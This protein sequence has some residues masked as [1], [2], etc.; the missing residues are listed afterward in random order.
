M[1]RLA[2]VMPAYNEEACIEAVARKWLSVLDI[3]PGELIVV[4]DGSR[5]KTGALLD[6]VAK[7]DRRLRVVHQK[8]AGHGAA[9]R[10]GYETAIVAGCGWIFQTDSDDQFETKDFFTLWNLRHEAPFVLGLRA[11]RSDPLA[12]KIISRIAAYWMGVLFQRIPRDAN[13][14]FRLFRADVLAK[15][16]EAVDKTV[17]APNLFLTITAKFAGIPMREV[18]VF[19]RERETGTVSI[20]RW[21]LLKV[22]FRSARELF[23]YRLSIGSK[24]SALADAR[25]AWAPPSQAPARKVG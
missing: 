22:C 9:V 4:N 3:V 14:P 19:H 11:H 24:K 1:E 16:L 7:T 23:H 21:K 25:A 18:P 20:V 6:A 13:A 17:F 10:N 2:I 5:D 12:R 15:L 8:N